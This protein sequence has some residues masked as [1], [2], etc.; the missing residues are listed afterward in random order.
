MRRYRRN[1]EM[2]ESEKM[3]M[4]AQARACMLWPVKG[5]SFEAT[6]PVNMTATQAKQQLAQLISAVNQLTPQKKA[7]RIKGLTTGRDLSKKFGSMILCPLIRRENGRLSPI[8]AMAGEAEL[9]PSEFA[10]LAVNT[11]SGVLA[12]LSRDNAWPR[13]IDGLW[14]LVG[15]TADNL[16]D[17]VQEQEGDGYPPRMAA[18]RQSLYDDEEVKSQAFDWGSP[19]FEKDRYGWGDAEVFE[20]EAGTASDDEEM[21]DMFPGEQTST[22]SEEDEVPEGEY[23]EGEYPEGEYQ[24]QDYQDIPFDTPRGDTR[25][26]QAADEDVR[27]M[28]RDAGAADAFTKSQRNKFLQRASRLGKDFENLYGPRTT[29]PTSL[30]PFLEMKKRTLPV[31][32]I[33]SFGKA[34]GAESQTELIRRLMDRGGSL[35]L[36][37]RSN[38]NTQ[39]FVS[40]PNFNTTMRKTASGRPVGGEPTWFP[41]AEFLTR[42]NLE[43]QNWNGDVTSLGKAYEFTVRWRQQKQRYYRFPLYIFK[44]VYDRR[45]AGYYDRDGGQVEL[46]FIKELSAPTSTFTNFRV[47]PALEKIERRRAQAE[48]RAETGEG[49]GDWVEEDRLMNPRRLAGPQYRQKRLPGPRERVRMH[50]RRYR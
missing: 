21:E 30:W 14:E 23:P 29:G 38:G 12:Q 46:Q 5:D 41:I 27:G 42:P 47:G 32:A 35:L 2:P 34:L 24:Q 13:G 48:Q 6:Q 43:P 11:V 31:P 10:T 37:V 45:Q 20:E 18:T 26:R 17:M 39:I 19:P 25:F 4:L 40:S 33:A 22:K 3:Q 50:R 49:G 8:E 9:D 28:E 7:E 1:N 15:E 16:L 36:V 44:E